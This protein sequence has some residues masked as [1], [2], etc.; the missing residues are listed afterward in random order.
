MKRK[1]MHP[2]CTILMA[3]T[4]LSTSLFSQT[5]MSSEFSRRREKLMAELGDAVAVFKSPDE[6]IRNSDVA[7]EYRQDS[8]FYYMTG[9]EE[10]NSVF[11]L[12]PSGENRF[13]MF[14]RPQNPMMKLWLGDLSGTEGAMEFF[15]ADTAYP[16][17]ELEKVL[18]PILRSAET[19][20]CSTPDRDFKDKIKSIAQ[21]EDA[22]R[23]KIKVV[24]HLHAMRQIKSISEIA[25][26]QKAVDITC[27]AHIEAM[28]MTSPGM[29]EYEVEALIEYVFRSAGSPR[30][31]FPSIVGS[32]PNSTVLHYMKNE[33]DMG[34]GDLLVM[35]I[36]AEY[37]YYSADVTRTIPVNGHF[38]DAQKA[39]YEIVLRANEAAI[40]RVRP[41]IPIADVY[42]HGTDIL[43]QGLYEL[44]L[45]TD[46]NSSWQ[47]RVWTIHGLGHW[48]GMDP[49]DVQ[50]TQESTGSAST[51][52]PGMVFT[53]EPGIYI[54]EDQ[55][56]MLRPFLYR[57]ASE[58][59][60]DTF[61]AAV[62]PVSEK[63]TAIGIRIEDD[64]LVTKEGYSVLSSAAP[65]TVEAIEAEMAKPSQRFLPVEAH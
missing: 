12:H 21:A 24:P 1:C 6:V 63:Y 22:P 62:K 53:I 43:K 61:I 28:R 15:G 54:G 20:Y 27:D 47:H 56:A 58:N 2:F 44:G 37:G 48:L 17:Q 33:R 55:L 41:G 50:G 7:Y 11:V 9:F 29:N 42:S 19:V 59:E 26:L 34:E 31:G 5:E 39:I 45:I 18:S 16:I 30:D 64:I 25:H 13:M 32:G 52:L 57:T 49:H 38:T 51:L 8:D 35:D 65:K 60:V 46:P 10:A 36:G 4:M 23:R 3:L 14:V 40:E